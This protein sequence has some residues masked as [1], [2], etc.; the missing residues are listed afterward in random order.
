MHLGA[1]KR[2][3]MHSSALLCIQDHY[4]VDVCVS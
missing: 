3:V 1:L 4:K 2:I